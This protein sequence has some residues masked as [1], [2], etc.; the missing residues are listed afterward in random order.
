MRRWPGAGT[1]HR[2]RGRDVQEIRNKLELELKALEHEIIH[3]LPKEI[4][5]AREL[6]DLRENAEYKAAIERQTLVRG[7]I[8]QVRQRLE[9][10]SRIR[11]DKLPL[12]T[13]HLG[14]LL[15]V[16]DMEND[17]EKTFELVVPE[18]ADP[19]SGQ[20]SIAS[21]IG[22][23]LIGKEEGDEVKIRTPNGLRTFE[24]ISLRTIHQ[25]KKDGDG[26]IA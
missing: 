1:A 23:G 11:I 4:Q 2:R 9:E 22:Q 3:E 6:G 13:A 18:A 8:D 5:T 21:P 25:R 16:L 26:D 19:A 20:L 15:T 10:L 7:R 17:E 14:S 24:V 12:E